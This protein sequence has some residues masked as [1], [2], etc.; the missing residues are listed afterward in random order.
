MIFSWG[1]KANNFLENH[2]QD[3]PQLVKL[4]MTTLDPQSALDVT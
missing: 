2:C 1:V 4:K 3:P